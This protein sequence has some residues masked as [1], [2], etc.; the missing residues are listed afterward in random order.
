MTILGIPNR[1]ENWKTARCFSPM[2]GD[3]NLRLK[4]ARKLGEP[5]GTDPSDVHLELF[6]KGMR[7]HLHQGR[8][9]KK[10]RLLSVDNISDLADR[11]SNLFPNLRG[12]IEDFGKFSDLGELNYNVSTEAGKTRLASNLLNTEIDVILTTPGHL[13]IGE[14]KGEMDLGADGK[15][16]LVHQLIRQYVMARILVNRLVSQ[17]RASPKKVVPFIVRSELKGKEQ[18]QVDFMVCEGWMNRANALEWDEIMNL[19]RDS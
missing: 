19:A 1:T 5:C 8:K 15:L 16:V 11:Y 13:F 2:F 12:R 10:D 17:A 4:L 7:D 6:W 18:A 14:A 9:R 3:R